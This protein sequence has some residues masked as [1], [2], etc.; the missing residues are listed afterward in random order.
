ML[1]SEAPGAEAT[2]G[3]DF[4]HAIFDSV[5]TNAKA[6]DNEGAAIAIEG[7]FRVKVDGATMT[8]NRQGG[9]LLSDGAM[10]EASNIRYS[11]GDPPRRWRKGK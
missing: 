7:P 6:S 2:G 10:V 3:R 8:N 5:F 1:P 11:A 4:P 9:F